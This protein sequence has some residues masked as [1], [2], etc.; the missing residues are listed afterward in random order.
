MTSLIAY[1]KTVLITSPPRLEC[2]ES[3]S[4]LQHDNLMAPDDLHGTQA[5]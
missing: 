1:Q 5:F 4:Y 2:E 3:L